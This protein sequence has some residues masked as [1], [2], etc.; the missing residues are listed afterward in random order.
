MQRVF[1]FLFINFGALFLGS[2]LMG[3]PIENEWY[4]QVNKAPWTPPGWV[5]GAAWFSIMACFA[6]FLTRSLR[7]N[8]KTSWV[9]YFLH[10]ALNI[11]WNPVFFR[12]HWVVL[13]LL[14]LILLFLT[15][16]WFFKQSK[17]RFSSLLLLPYLI[18]LCIAI[19]LNG[20]ILFMN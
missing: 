16:I 18:W 2:L 20:Y 14:L 17:D 9:I 5:F 19:S 4:Q 8:H 6:I 12:A 3:S 15:L 11:S 13:G 7:W 10:I 1:L